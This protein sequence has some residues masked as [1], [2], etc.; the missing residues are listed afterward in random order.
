MDTV[1]PP[2]VQVSV[3][4]LLAVIE[5]SV[6][7]PDAN[8]VPLQPPLAVQLVATGDVDHVS[9]GV[10]LPVAVVWL[11]EKLMVPAV[12]ACASEASSI[13]GRA[14]SPYETLCIFNP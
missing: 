10:R 14:N 6:S 11:P 3:Y 9:T 8:F 12:C 13:S 4:D 7:L 1:P 5:V 2:Q